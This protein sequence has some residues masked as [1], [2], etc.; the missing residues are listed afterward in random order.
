MSF[1]SFKTW[2]RAKRASTTSTATRAATK[3]HD[4]DDCWVAQGC[5]VGSP[6]GL[7]SG[8]S[9]RLGTVNLGFDRLSTCPVRFLDFRMLVPAIV[10]GWRRV[11]MLFLSLVTRTFALFV[12]PKNDCI[13]LAVDVWA[14]GFSWISPKKQWHCPTNNTLRKIK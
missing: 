10:H 7:R 9:Q 8:S 6:T 12:D 14:R 1:L 3:K 2:T 11:R 5:F 4:D 13:T